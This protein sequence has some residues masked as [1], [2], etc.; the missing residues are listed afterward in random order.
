MQIYDILP[1]TAFTIMTYGTVALV[2]FGSKLASRA[3]E[4][5]KESK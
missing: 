4:K 5:L 1:L 3:L 2:V